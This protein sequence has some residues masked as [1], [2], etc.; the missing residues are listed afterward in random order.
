MNFLQVHL[1]LSETDTIWLLDFPGT[2]VAEDSEIAEGIKEKNQ[3]YEEVSFCVWCNNFIVWLFNIR[4]MRWTWR[5]SLQEFVVA[6][7][8][9]F[10]DC[11]NEMFVLFIHFA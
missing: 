5:S 2:S 7:M 8:L 9:I 10:R 4:M 1:T 6:I 3:K 11:I